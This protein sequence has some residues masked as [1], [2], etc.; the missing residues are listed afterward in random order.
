MKI[1]TSAEMKEIDRRTIEDIGIPGPVLMENAGIQVF[2]VLQALFPGLAQEKIVIVAGKGNNGGDG[3]VVARH[4]RNHGARPQVLLLGSK[5]EVRGDAALNLKIA[6]AVGVAV[7]EVRSFSDWK[8]Q[9]KALQEAAIIVDAIFGTGLVKPAAGLYATAIESINKT[10]AFKLTVDIPSGLSSDTYEVIGPAV[11][12]DLTV[13]LAA[14]KIAHVLP[15][16]E[17]FVGDFV[18]ADISIPPFVFDDEALKLEMVEKA[19]LLACFRKRKRESHKGN[20]GHLFI[21]AGSLG[22]TGAAA[23][24]ARAAYKTGAGL[25]TVGTPRTCLPIVARSMMELMTEPLAETE[26]K[27]ISSEA[28]PRV[29]DLIKEKDAVIIGP[30]I[31]TQESTRRFVWNL[32]PKIRQPLVIDADALNILSQKQELLKKLPKPAILTPHPGEFARLL[33]LTVPEV[34]GKR[35]ELVPCFA[36][37]HGVIL[38]LKGYRTLVGAPDGRVF[39]NPTGNPGMATG[40]TGDVLSGMIGSL[41]MQQKDPLM[42]ALAAV[43]L[44]GMSGDLASRRVGERAIVAGDLIRFLPQAVKAME[45][46]AEAQRG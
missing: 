22:K 8:K 3:L 38:V 13:T 1:L 34:L 17:E 36:Q 32:I 24:A 4:L 30:G 20:Y 27:T 40:G 11:K 25:V 14:P 19:S 10:R 16:A 45:M 28:L 37:K 21:I 39:V 18:V 23:L 42:A 31:S 44:H 9:Q 6:L 41:L 35:L 43:Y 29:L 2:R 7:K 12:A 26:E 33:G 15:P 5:G 46:E